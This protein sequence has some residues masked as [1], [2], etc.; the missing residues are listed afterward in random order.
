[1]V[2]GISLATAAAWQAPLSH[3]RGPLPTLPALPRAAFT[4]E[5]DLWTQTWHY[6]SSHSDLDDALG[7]LCTFPQTK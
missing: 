1:M 6:F 2:S 5:T 4:L 7:K 3:D